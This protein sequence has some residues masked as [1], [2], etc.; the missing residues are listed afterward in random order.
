MRM[1]GTGVAVVLALFAR[2]AAAQP[3][4]SAATVLANVQQFYANANQLTSRFR[5]TV[6]NATFHASKTSEGELWVLKPAH[7]R[8]DYRTKG[9]GHVIVTRS[10]IFEVPSQPSA[11]YKQLLFVVDPSDWHVTESIVID[12]SGNTNA[13]RFLSPDLTATV[14]HSWFQVN[15]SSLPTYRLV[16]LNQTGPAASSGS[17]VATPTANPGPATSPGHTP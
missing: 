16:Q 14:D 4:P 3:P 12:T 15:P 2:S 9:N 11:P 7:F 8:F 17:A 10:F 5:Q 13:F 6:T 1:F